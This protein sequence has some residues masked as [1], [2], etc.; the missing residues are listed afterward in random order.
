M[1]AGTFTRADGVP[2]NF[3]VDRMGHLCIMVFWSQDTPGFELYLKQIKEL[4]VQYPVRFDV[5]SFNLDELP[6]G[7]TATLRKLKLD[8]T[9]MRLPGGR[10]H[11]AFRTYA[12]EDPAGIFVN[13]Y[14]RVLLAPT[15]EEKFALSAQRINDDRYLAQLQSLF[16]G[17]FLVDTSDAGQTST[18]EN[19][20][21]CFVAVPF[22][23]R[24]KTE[25]AL[26][27]YQKA[28]KLCADAIK[29]GAKAEDISAVRDHR[30]IALLGMWNLAGEPKHLAEAV[31]EAKAALATELP[32][33]A[34]VVA[35]FCLAKASAA[36][37]GRARRSRSTYSL[38]ARQRW[39]GHSVHA[40]HV[41]AKSRGSFCRGH[42]RNQCP[43]VGRCGGGHP[44]A[45]RQ[46]TRSARA[47]SRQIAGASRWRRSHAVACCRVSAR[48]GPYIR[49][50]EG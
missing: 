12:Q 34:D 29:A 22:R 8:W 49:R 46:H 26:A 11:P 27:N 47:I 6:D 25:Q 40:L 19:I 33:G 43:F 44:G 1:F 23:Y 21:K 45:G 10:N 42:G 9:V 38:C 50:A 48:S 15:P 2:L 32:P 18:L 31:E 4:E 41:R 17:D 28:A 36:R 16:I 13:A 7:G 24:L 39:S 5:F 14:G 35:R 30:I 3:P 20:Q 37:G